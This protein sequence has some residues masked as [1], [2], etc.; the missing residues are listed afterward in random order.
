MEDLIFTKEEFVDFLCFRFKHISNIRPFVISAT[1]TLSFMPQEK[2]KYYIS[3]FIENNKMP[4]GSKLND[5][6]IETIK[7]LR[8]TWAK[9]RKANSKPGN[10]DM[11]KVYYAGL[12][13]NMA[14]MFL[15]QMESET[16]K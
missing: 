16:N 11:K 5:V 2:Q 15:L 12:S 3:T 10:L 4:D 6:S 13:L 9:V 7:H 14:S 1:E 8:N